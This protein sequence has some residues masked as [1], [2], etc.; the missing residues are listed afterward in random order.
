MKVVTEQWVHDGLLAARSGDC[1]ILLADE[2]WEGFAGRAWGLGPVPVWETEVG[3]C[4]SILCSGGSSRERVDDSL[5]VRIKY[6]L[7]KV[8]TDSDFKVIPAC[9][10]RKVPDRVC[11]KVGKG[12]RC[13]CSIHHRNQTHFRLRPRARTAFHGYLMEN[14]SNQSGLVYYQDLPAI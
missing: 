4:G 14:V 9:S 10:P 12:W 8:S 1:D 6:L 5:N 3:S 13:A 7:F 11:A 2:N